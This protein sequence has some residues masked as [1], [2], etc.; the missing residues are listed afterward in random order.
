M[1]LWYQRWDIV[2][3]VDFVKQKDIVGHWQGA[4]RFAAP[5]QSIFPQLIA[6]RGAN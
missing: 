6:L 4:R 1:R 3:K 2:Q 5:K